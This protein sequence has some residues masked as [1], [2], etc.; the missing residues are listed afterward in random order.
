MG[1]V[2]QMKIERAPVFTDMTDMLNKWWKEQTK[3]PL[4]KPM[5][6]RHVVEIAHAAGWTL[7]EC[8]EAL[9]ITWSFT[10]AA[11]ETALRRIV[12]EQVEKQ[13]PVSN[14]SDVAVTKAA[15]ESEK[16]ESLSKEE[17][18]QRLRELK[19]QLRSKG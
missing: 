5:K 16:K 11:F 1:K 17:N 7:N 8:Y 4:A 14:I 19:D 9:G 2:I 18:I 10:E 6:I 12:D 3:K 13:R 15:L